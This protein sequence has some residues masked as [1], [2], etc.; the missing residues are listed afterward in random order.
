MPTFQIL[1][2]P[3]SSFTHLGKLSEP[4][5]AASNI[6][7]VTADSKPGYPCRV[8]LDDA[9]VGEAL[10]LLPHAH[11]RVESPY[12]ASG[13]IFVRVLPRERE[14]PPDEVPSF[15]RSRLVSLRAYDAGSSLVTAIACK[16][17]TA[18]GALMDLFRRPDVEYVQIHNAAYGCFLCEARRPA[19]AQDRA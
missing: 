6:R 4:E 18:H 13:P 2:L 17:D 11:H 12:L 16:G 7:R 10:F 8:S 5:L 19:A 9:E 14:L 15:L 3:A 1:G